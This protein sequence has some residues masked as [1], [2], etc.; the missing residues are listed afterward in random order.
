MRR[1]LHAFAAGWVGLSLLIALP[2]TADI[3]VIGHYTFANGDTLTRASYYTSKRIRTTLP[4]GDEI[5]YDHSAKQ[6]ALVDHAKKQYWKGPKVQA[7]SIATRIRSARAKAMNE[8]VTPDER[9]QWT[10]VYD[11]LGSGVSFAPTGVDR[12]ICGYACT[13]WVLMA[14]T[15]MTQQRWVARALAMPDFSPEIEKTVLA[16]M[17]DPVGSGLMKLV[18]QGHVTNGLTLA[19][20]IQFKTLKQH[21]EMSWEAVQVLSGTIPPEAWEVPKDYQPW[22][23]PAPAAGK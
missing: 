20:R 14:G 22:Q 11:A 7:D 1:R 19:G 12:K 23:P 10:E 9:A 13:E 18:L 17:L 2:A 8:S 6:I 15:Y 16:S 4:N 3:T 21:G 5:I